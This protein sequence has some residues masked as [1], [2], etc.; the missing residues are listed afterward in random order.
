M[1]K[2]VRLLIDFAVIVRP[3]THRPNPRLQPRAWPDRQHRI[4]PVLTHLGNE[5]Y[6]PRG[7]GLLP[8][9]GS[10]YPLPP[11]ISP[12]SFP[13]QYPQDIESRPAA[14]TLTESIS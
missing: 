7:D 14:T 10:S 4:A 12:S 9:K 1:P 6:V 8:T 13:V 2:L 3:F 11:T 5:D